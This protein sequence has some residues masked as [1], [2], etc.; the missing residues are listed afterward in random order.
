ACRCAAIAG[1]RPDNLA[2]IPQAHQHGDHRCPTKPPERARHEARQ[3]L[4][5]GRRVERLH[6]WDTNEVEEIEQANPGNACDEVNPTKHHEEVC[7]EV[8]RQIYGIQG[9]GLLLKM[10]SVA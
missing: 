10:V 2:P 1:I 8:A 3:D 5:F 4:A 6:E 7:V 9:E